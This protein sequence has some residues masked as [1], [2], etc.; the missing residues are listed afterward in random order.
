M[1]KEKPKVGDE[2]WFVEWPYEL[3]YDSNGELDPCETKTKQKRVSTKEEAEKLAREMY[4]ETLAC[5]GWVEYWPARYE[6]YD[7]GDDPYPPH[8][9]PCGKIEYYEAE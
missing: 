8:W 7:D 6:H 9:E 2:C 5:G 4:P 3:T 1:K